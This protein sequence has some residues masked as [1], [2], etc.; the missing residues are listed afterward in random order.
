MVTKVYLNGCSLV[1]GTGLDHEQKL[2]HLLRSNH[3]NITVDNFSYPGKSNHLICKDIYDNFEN[4]DAFIIGFTWSSRFSVGHVNGG[5]MS[6]GPNFVA[7]SET[8]N[9]NRDHVSTAYEEALEDFRV[10]FYKIYDDSYWKSYSDMLVDST[11]TLLE[12]YNKKV[13][14]F[15][16]EE[17]KTKL[18]K[19]SRIGQIDYLRQKDGHLNAEGTR[20]LYNNIVENFSEVLK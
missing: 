15:T 6:M 18:C 2:E 5:I 19:L 11:I 4:Y 12:K 14:A 9:I 3:S 8:L 13:L 1:W 10:N 20:T 16:W 7:G 17:R